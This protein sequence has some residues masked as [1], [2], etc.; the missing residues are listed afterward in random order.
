[1]SVVAASGDHL[2]A[3]RSTADTT[4][5]WS[6]AVLSWVLHLGSDTMLANGLIRPRHMQEKLKPKGEVVE[7]G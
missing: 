2:V 4:F 6:R 5:Q 7:Q 1:M 3:T